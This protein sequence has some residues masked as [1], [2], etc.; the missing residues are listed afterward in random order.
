MV[1]QK[2]A[3]HSTLTGKLRSSL[4]VPPPIPMNL[5]ASLSTRFNS[6]SRLDKNSSF[7]QQLTL[8]D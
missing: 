3:I 4:S 5:K 7:L 2:L 8:K 6:T 1:A